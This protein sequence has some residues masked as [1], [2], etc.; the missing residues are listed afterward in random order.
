MFYPQQLRFDPEHGLSYPKPGD[1]GSTLR[2]TY[3]R[4]SC[5]PPNIHRLLASIGDY[6]YTQSNEGLRVD[7]FV[8]SSLKCKLGGQAATL[9]QE[10]GYPWSGEVKLTIRGVKKASAEIAL[11]IPGWCEGAVVKVNGRN[12][13]PAPSG[14][15]VSV[16]RKW[17]DGDAVELSLPMQPRVIPP[18]PKVEAQVDRTALMYGPVVYCVEQADNPGIDLR[19]ITVEQKVEPKAGFDAQL[20]GGVVK[21]TMPA[22]QWIVE[23]ESKEITLTAIPY[24][25]W[26]NREIGYMDVWLATDRRIALDPPAKETMADPYCA[27]HDQ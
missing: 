5:C 26:A 15:Y 21:M 7:L 24:Y 11:R 18:N 16:K 20:L 10:T 22:K 27:G 3:L 23:G 6:I 12:A 14:E 19:K 8:A 13:Q 17:N 1:A 4:C 9:I 25:A 2:S